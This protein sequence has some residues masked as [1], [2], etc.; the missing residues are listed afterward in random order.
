MNKETP[1]WET[2]RHPI[3]GFIYSDKKNSKQLLEKRLQ[4]EAKRKQNK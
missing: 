2:N 3:T 4:R 1:F